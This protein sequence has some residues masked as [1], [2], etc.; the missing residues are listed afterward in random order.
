VALRRKQ[1]VFASMPGPL[2]NSLCPLS[3]AW[4]TTLGIVLGLGGL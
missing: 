4:V 2:A 1:A 3:H